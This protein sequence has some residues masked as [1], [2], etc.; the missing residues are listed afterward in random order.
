MKV[1][2]KVTRAFRA[3]SGLKVAWSSLGNVLMV[4]LI[5]VVIGLAVVRLYVSSRIVIEARRLQ[6]MRDEVN[7]LRES[8]HAIEMEIAR[9]TYGPDLL[10]QAG[11]LGLKPAEQIVVVEP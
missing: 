5:L 9:H 11:E 6:G 4:V 2:E 3:L 10:R 7:D 8:N 1:G